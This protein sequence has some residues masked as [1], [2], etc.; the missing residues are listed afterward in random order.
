MAIAAL[1]KRFGGRDMQIN[2]VDS[3]GI[4]ARHQAGSHLPFEASNDGA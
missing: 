3:I 4:H 2:L 1:R